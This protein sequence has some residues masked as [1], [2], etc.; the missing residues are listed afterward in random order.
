MNPLAPYESL[1]NTD[2]HCI[3]FMAMAEQELS[4]FFTGVTQLFGPKQAEHSAEDWLRE[5]I[6]ID[7][8]PAST[9][10]F[11]LI[12]TKVATR[13]ASRVT[14]SSLSTQFTNA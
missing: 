7:G 9:R 12:T 8:L 13:L 11:R 3:D 2:P 10:E 6:E 14:A 1:K 5:V 4:A